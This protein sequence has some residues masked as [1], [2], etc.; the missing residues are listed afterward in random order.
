MKSNNILTN[1]VRII[2]IAGLVLS[3]KGIAVKA[4]DLNKSEKTVSELKV[5]KKTEKLKSK[6]EDYRFWL[7]VEGTQIDYPVVQAE[8]N[9]FYIKRD[10][11]K[12]ESIAGTPFLDYRNNSLNDKNTIIYAHHMRNGS[13]FGEL[14]KF[15][16][17]DFFNQNNKVTVE[18]N[19]KVNTYE[20]FSVYV[21][22]GTTDYLKVDFLDNEYQEYL[23]NAIEK[24]M[25]DSKVEVNKDD[26][27]ITFSTCSYEFKD[28]RTVVHAKLVK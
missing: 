25:Y 4:I 5:D 16:S 1:L 10:F 11:N 24:S 8:D 9:D 14:K 23:N 12:E 19:G 2:A 15:K 26:K 28:A 18:I 7:K 17:E 6:N 20:V 27:I 22:A 3:C 13:M 21:T